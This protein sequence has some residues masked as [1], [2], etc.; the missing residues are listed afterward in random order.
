MELREED[1]EEEEDR[2]RQENQA[3]INDPSAPPEVD[4]T[5]PYAPS[6]DDPSRSSPHS[7]DSRDPRMVRISTL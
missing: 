4:I 5:V 6:D 1:E 2:A 7:R 3:L